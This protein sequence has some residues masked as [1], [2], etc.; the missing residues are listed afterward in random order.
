[1]W[2]DP[3]PSVDVRDERYQVNYCSE[4]E[5]TRCQTRWKDDGVEWSGQEY[6]RQLIDQKTKAGDLLHRDGIRKMV[7]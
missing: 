1:M 4:I 5:K 3:R 7:M 2:R 6:Q